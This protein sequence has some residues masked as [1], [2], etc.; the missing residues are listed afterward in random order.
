[1]KKLKAIS[2]DEFSPRN[3]WMNGLHVGDKLDM[4]YD[5]PNYANYYLK[6]LE[7]N[8]YMW[9]CRRFTGRSLC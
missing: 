1:M 8:I 9:S 5:D 3:L 6:V 4:N 2:R 7:R